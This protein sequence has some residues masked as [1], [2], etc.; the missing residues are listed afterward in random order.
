MRITERKRARERKRSGRQSAIAQSKER[1]PRSSQ[2]IPRT[3]VTTH[4][5]NVSALEQRFDD[6]SSRRAKNRI[7]TTG[8]VMAKVANDTR[9]RLG[10]NYGNNYST[11]WSLCASQPAAKP[12]KIP[13]H[14]SRRRPQKQQS[15]SRKLLNY[16][17]AGG[18][19]CC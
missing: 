7:C 19:C 8:K 14:R 4:S 2:R 12:I 3:A 11:S 1:T 5:Q 15:Q 6:C 9:M 16:W 10:R 17:L 13:T 18:C